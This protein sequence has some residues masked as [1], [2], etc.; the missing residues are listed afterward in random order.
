MLLDFDFILVFLVTG[1]RIASLGVSAHTTPV[2]NRFKPPEGGCRLINNGSALY[3]VSIISTYEQS[4][5]NI[6][7]NYPT[8]TTAGTRYSWAQGIGGNGFQNEPRSQR[9]SL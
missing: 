6:R 9:Y 3:K 7:I 4:I 5:S 2:T 1:L 8:G